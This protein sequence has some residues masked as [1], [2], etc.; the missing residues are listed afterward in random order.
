MPR[1]YKGARLD[2]GNGGRNGENWAILNMVG[3]TPCGRPTDQS[4]THTNGAS[5]A[6]RKDKKRDTGQNG[7]ERHRLTS[8]ERAKGSREGV[9]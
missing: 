8:V 9:G 7:R 2:P 1:P 5:H 6:P 3:A 4:L